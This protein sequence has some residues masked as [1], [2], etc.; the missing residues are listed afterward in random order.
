MFD[1]HVVVHDLVAQFDHL[2]HVETE[3]QQVAPELLHVDGRLLHQSLVLLETEVHFQCRV[4]AEHFHLAFLLDLFGVVQDQQPQVSVDVLVVRGGALALQFLQLVERGVHSLLVVRL[5]EYLQQHRVPLQ[6]T[7]LEKVE[8]YVQHPC[9]SHFVFVLH[10][11]VL[12]LYG[13]HHQRIVLFLLPT[14]I[15]QLFAGTLRVSARPH[16]VGVHLF[17]QHVFV[18][19]LWAVQQSDHRVD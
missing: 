18:G 9:L 15:G 7:R 1:E 3:P 14:V 5:H 10:R 13:I 11:L 8:Q 19:P 6:R 16:V 2:R 17:E 12:Q 4:N